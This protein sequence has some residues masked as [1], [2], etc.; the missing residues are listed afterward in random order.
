MPISRKTTG[1]YFRSYSI[2][3]SLPIVIG[4]I[5]G[6]E[7]IFVRTIIPL[8]FEGVTTIAD[9]SEQLTA[10]IVLAFLLVGAY[11]TGLL[12]ERA[13]EVS[14]VG[15]DVA[16]ERYHSSAGRMPA[17][18]APLKFLATFFTLGFGGSGGLVGPTA[19]IGQ[20]TASYFSKWLKLPP[21]KSRILA[22]CGIAGCVSGLL[23]APFGAAV[24]ALELCYM[25]SI[26]YEHLIP[27]LLSSVSAYIMSA[28][29][30]GTFPFGH[31]LEQPHLFRTIVHHTAFPWSLDY[32]AYCAVA[33]LVT[34][35]IGILFIRTFL[36]IQNFSKT[37]IKS[38]Y[39]SVIG[40]LFVGL[41][42]ILFF[43]HRLADVLGQ[44]GDLVERCAT[45][46]YPL[47]IAASLLVGR[48]V[49]TFL[50]TGFG[51]SGGLFS[52]TVLMGG[53]SGTV[54][55]GILGTANVRVLVTTGIAAALAGVINVP[56]AA[57]IIVVEVFGV[58]FII[59]AAIGSAIAFLLAK[60]VVIFPHIRP[61]QREFEK[62]ES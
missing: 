52:P 36:V 59:P 12:T 39:G 27:V 3:L 50:T 28:R 31:L 42:A 2:D 7:A 26:V 44:P 43:R 11:L 10:P 17:K 33:A 14:G 1:Q 45:E 35:L 34:T 22:L 32:L 6:L 51:G 16:I 62:V 58:S 4:L 9:V 19:A 37:K 23:H 53:L 8:T 20:G 18:F 13:R 46:G 15:F 24:F 48:W 56:M 30:V 55:A 29:I 40:A 57:V 49:T 47:G 38:R 60:N 5:C 54:V 25:G 41:V 61:R 21:D